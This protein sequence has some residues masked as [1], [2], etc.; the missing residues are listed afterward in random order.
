MNRHTILA[1]CG[2]MLIFS[3][4]PCR[5]QYRMGQAGVGIYA[6]MQKLVGGSA[7][8]SN[9]NHFEGLSVLY[10]FSPSVTSV[11]SISAGWVKPRSSDSHFSVLEN[12]P[13]KTYIYPWDV[14]VRLNLSKGSIVPYIGGG[15]GMTYW[16]LREIG[17][18]DSWFP[19]PADGTSKSTLQNNLSLVAC[20]GIS[21]FLSERFNCDIGVKYTHLLDQPMDNIGISYTGGT[22]DVN[23]GIIKAYIT[24]AVCTGS[25]KDSD[26]DG[27]PDKTD[28]A[29]FA[30]EDFDNFEDGDG[31]PDI[32]NDNDGIPDDRD[33]APNVAE[34]KDG[35]E[36][37]DG[38]P[39]LDN[40]NDGIPDIRDKCPD[41]AEDFD[42]FEDEDGCP[43]P[44]N[45][46]DG[47]PDVKDKC[48]DQPETVNGYQD[49]D[50][51]PDEKPKP[52]VPE[53]GATVIL[54]DIT[55][56]FGS[57]RLTIQAQKKLD[58]LAAEL[59]KHRDIRLEVR[60]YTDS[61][62]SAASN[63]GL[64]QNRAESVKDYLVS[65]GVRSS[66]IRALGCGEANPVA[67]NTTNAGRARNRRIEF[68]RLD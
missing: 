16:D 35:F 60:G 62:G 42:G 24:L 19:I 1:A 64:S 63:L 31:A 7:D 30:M 5:A 12:T 68:S 21:L 57:S 28:M 45:D 15:A 3:A 36:D 25:E 13:Y 44:D 48:P 23:N 56:A 55:F 37:G 34:D 17:D 38:V 52:V 29:P 2:A 6:G 4:L 43:D 59:V 18:D 20:A 46:K 27:I 32:D 53:R 41:A 54:P 33:K 65:S 11:F 51:C 58:E 14:T 50:G 61:I 66:Q 8:Y 9:V 40:D 47:I 22:A 10:S 26:G 49:T 67:P 39:D